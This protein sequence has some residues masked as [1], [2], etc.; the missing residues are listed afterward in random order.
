MK[1][2]F[3]P[4]IATGLAMALTLAAC[5]P[6]AAPAPAPAAAPV[7]PAADA[8][9]AADAPADADG[10]EPVH[11]MAFAMM[12][13]PNAESGRQVTMAAQTA[14]WY[15]NEVLGGFPSLG[16][17]PVQIT[18]IDST[19][20]AAQASL[21]FEQALDSGNYS[22][23]IGNS[24]SS[25]A[26]VQ[27]P[28][29]ERFEIPMITGAAANIAISQQGST[30]SFQPAAVAATFIPLQFA[31]LEYYAD[32]MGIDIY[33]L[34]IGLI[35]ANDAWGTDNAQNT[36]NHIEER[37]L[38]LALDMAYEVA[39]FTDATPLVTALMNAEVDVVLPSSYPSDLSLIFTAMGALNYNPLIVGGGA[40]MTWPSLFVD[41][42]EAVNGLTSVDS[43]VWDQTG[44][45]VHE[46]MMMMNE[47]Y[48]Q[49]FGE[50]IPG[51]GGPTLTSIMTAYAAIERI[52]SDDPIAIRDE[53]RRTDETVC[54]WFAIVNGFSA[55]DPETGQ[56]TGAL[57]VI[58]Q[59]QNNRPTAVFPP[60]LAASELLNPQTMQPF[61]R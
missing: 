56:N 4:F 27:L 33:D 44:A 43:W 41:I 39:T 15:I 25:I 12:S 49:Q 48:E 30:F 18:V 3:L 52:G 13:G 14:E 29:A 22:V 38:N 40:A 46:G 9:D 60:E 23:V 32:L 51:Q 59:W 11:F 50:F 53:L 2:K 57:P 21:P 1:K 61:E 10:L 16:G 6:A 42:G 5:T 47:W 36:R 7:A 8:A 58:L 17:R 31:F 34:N 45:R 24:N 26:L 28:I 35:Y 20:D 54:D 37:G 55:F 19:S